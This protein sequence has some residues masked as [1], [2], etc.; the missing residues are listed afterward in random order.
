M[1]VKVSIVSEQALKTNFSFPNTKE[2]GIVEQ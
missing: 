1:S 2:P